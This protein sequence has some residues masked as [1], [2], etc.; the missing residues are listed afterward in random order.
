MKIK[1]IIILGLMFFA[2]QSSAQ[3][4]KIYNPDLDVNKQFEEAMEKAKSQNKHIMLQI[5]GN[6]CAWCIRYHRFIKNEVEL[7]SMLNADYVVVLINYSP[8]YKDKNK[9]FFKKLGSPLRFGFP[10]FVVTDS[11]GKRLHTQNSWYL[12]KDSSFDKGKVKAFFRNWTVKA[13]EVE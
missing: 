13:V 6:W 11:E 9:E 8:R 3:I 10:V 2:L 12:E 5:G 1:T 4:N 7:D